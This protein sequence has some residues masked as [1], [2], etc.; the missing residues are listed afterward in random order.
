MSGAFPISRKSV[1][2]VIIAILLLVTLTLI[3]LL[4]RS[5]PVTTK[6]V[7]IDKAALAPM[8]GIVVNSG[9]KVT[10]VQPGSVAEQAGIQPGDS[11][12]AVDGKPV[13][14]PA[15]ATQAERDASN[16]GEPVTITVIRNGQKLSIQVKAAPPIGRPGP[17]P[18]PLPGNFA[19]L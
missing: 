8:I 13:T 17:T 9:L 2:A 7:F 11:L 14:S 6:E 10:E 1:I 18:T 4:P 5:Q 3:V 19:I 12:E 16:K 15:E